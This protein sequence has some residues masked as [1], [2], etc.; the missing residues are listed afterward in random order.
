MIIE[1]ILQAAEDD[2]AYL[3]DDLNDCII[4][5]TINTQGTTV[6]YGY[7]SLVA[8]HVGHEGMDLEDAIEHVNYN[9]VG[10]GGANVPIIMMERSDYE[11]N[12][13][14]KETKEPP[15]SEETEV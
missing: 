3:F 12:N 14:N 1:E 4:G 2:G 15:S 13:K 9:I 11:I 8:Y 5:M 7:E 10:V 6:I